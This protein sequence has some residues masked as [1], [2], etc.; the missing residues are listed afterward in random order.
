MKRLK[1]MIGNR[2]I[3][4]RYL[5]N[6]LVWSNEK[7]KLVK[8]LEG[9]FVEFST[10]YISIAPNDVRF[11]EVEKI[12]KVFFNDVEALELKNVDFVDY[13]YR[14]HFNSPS[15]KETLLDKL[16]WVFSESEAGVTVKFEG[17]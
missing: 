14:V 11:T 6:N 15:D 5:G 16:G 8:I 1:L 17:E 9:C 4:R 2:E 7:V 3:T 13:R 12:K 10:P